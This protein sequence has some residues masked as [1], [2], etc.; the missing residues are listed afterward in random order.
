MTRY[1]LYFRK[2]KQMDRELDVMMSNEIKAQLDS[3]GATNPGTDE[4]S[5]MVEDISKMYKVYIEGAKNKTEANE[6]RK[7]F[8]REAKAR[9]LDSIIR[10]VESS[11]P[12]ITYVGLFFVGLN[13]EKTGAITTSTF[14]NLFNGIKLPKFGK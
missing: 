3:L 4:H 1:Y 10:V 12:I 8:E 13:F 5:K 11:V 6:R 2:E 9:K 14:R 7:Q